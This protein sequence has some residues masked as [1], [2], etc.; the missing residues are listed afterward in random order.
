MSAHSQKSPCSHAS[1]KICFAQLLCTFLPY[2]ELE[3]ATW[4]NGNDLQLVHAAFIIKIILIETCHRSQYL[5]VIEHLSLSNEQP[6]KH[7][8]YPSWIQVSIISLLTLVASN[9]FSYL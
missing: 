8:S 4:I 6:L 5:P 9:S 1:I 3:E 7:C 2:G